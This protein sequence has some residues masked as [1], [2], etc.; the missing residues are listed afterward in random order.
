MTTNTKLLA[1]K[2]LVMDFAR[3]TFLSGIKLNKD[4][5]SCL[6]GFFYCL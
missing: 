5:E 2:R 6:C 3:L 1:L 4:Q